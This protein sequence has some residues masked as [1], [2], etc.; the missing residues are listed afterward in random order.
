MTGVSGLPVVP[1]ERFVTRAELAEIM[2][3]SIDSV[4]R[5]RQKG[6]PCVTWGLRTVRFQ[7]STA[8]AWAQAQKREEA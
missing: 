6:L 8:L 5:M 4:D 3:V 2:G 1:R 7:V